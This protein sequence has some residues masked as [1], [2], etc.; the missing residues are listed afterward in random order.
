MKIVTHNGHFHGDE[1]FA[2]AT[3]LLKYPDAEVIRSRDPN[4]IAQG[5]IVLDVGHIYDFNLMRFDHHQSQGAGERTNGIPY[6]SS[7]LI[8]KHFGEE[9][10]GGKEEAQLIDDVI[11]T[12]LDAEDNAKVFSTA[13][14]AGL[15]EYSLGDFVES[16][17]RGTNTLQSSEEAFFKALV[18]CR[19][20]LKREID[21]A[22]QRVLDWNKVR[23]IYE[24]S[25]DKHIIVLN[26]YLSWGRALIETEALF[27]IYPRTDGS[28]GV[29]GVLKEPNTF[30]RKKLFP[31]SWA[32]L[33]GED[34]VKKT[35]VLDATFCHRSRHLAGAKTKE[36]AIALAEIALNA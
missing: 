34:L 26:T 24:K 36:S 4:V 27:V 21:I 31:V 18:P 2:V 15:K 16:F 14:V 5:D 10:A 28:W 25:E 20:L 1:V 32:G 23:D 17:A 6:A 35:G 33:D 13:I 9:I 30:M 22:R 8:W 12:P 7:G 19:E 29:Q 11:M 3:L